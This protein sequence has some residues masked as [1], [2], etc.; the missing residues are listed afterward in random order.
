MIERPTYFI[1]YFVEQK[2][3]G[4]VKVYNLFLVFY[5]GR[6]KRLV[7]TA[8][9]NRWHLKPSNTVRDQLTSIHIIQSLKTP[10]TTSTRLTMATTT[11]LSVLHMPTRRAPG[12]GSSTWRLA[13]ATTTYLSSPP[14]AVST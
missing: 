11:Y 8:R 12:A 9:E 10:L 14:V 1:H 5:R 4:G 2:N 3:G 13:M 6:C 7:H